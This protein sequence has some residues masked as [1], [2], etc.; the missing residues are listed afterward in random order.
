MGRPGYEWGL[1]GPQL[2]ELP[3]G[4]VMLV[5][6]CF[7]GGGAYR[8]QF[9]DEG[10]AVGQPVNDREGPVA[11]ALG[12]RLAH[13]RVGGERG[14]QQRPC[15]RAHDPPRGVGHCHGDHRHRHRQ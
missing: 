6:V 5:A 15:E 14:D 12:E 8:G 3:S 11:E 2:V 10:F 7:L 9:I 1:E 13:R 4:D